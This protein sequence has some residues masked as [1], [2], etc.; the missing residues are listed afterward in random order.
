MQQGTG[1]SRHQGPRQTGPGGSYRDPPPIDITPDGGYRVHG[2]GDGGPRQ[3][4]GMRRP[5]TLGGIVTLVVVALVLI[6]AFALGVLTFLIAIP[7]VI[8]AIVAALIF[9]LVMRHR[10]RTAVRAQQQQ[11]GGP[12][13]GP[14]S[15]P[16]A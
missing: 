11:G 9:G 6:G 13:A 16:G 12:G 15:T 10:L 8:G 2:G 7:V 3:A 14:G 5:S 1:G 4:G